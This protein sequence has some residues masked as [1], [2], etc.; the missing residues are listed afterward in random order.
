M[1]IWALPAANDTSGNSDGFHTKFHI[2]VGIFASFLLTE[3]RPDL[4][5]N[6]I[7]G[8]SV[9]WS[10]ETQLGLLKIQLGFPAAE[11]FR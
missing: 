4:S 6:S 11:L 9:P 7:W 2:A 10:Q 5:V 3:S 1:L 8:I